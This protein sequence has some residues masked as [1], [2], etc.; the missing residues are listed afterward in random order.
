MRFYPVLT[1][2]GSISLYNT[3]V[4]DIYHSSIGAYTEALNKYTLPSGIIEYCKTS[5][6]VNIL[7]TCFGLG[8]N[9]RVS[10]TEIIK[11]NP[12]CKINL[13]I[14]ENDPYVLAYSL[15]V[16]IENEPGLVVKALK[17]VILASELIKQAIENILKDV[18]FTHKQRLDLKLIKQLE[19]IKSYNVKD[20]IDSKVMLH[21]I[22]YPPQS[23][24]NKM[25][26]KIQYK[27]NSINIDLWLCDARHAIQQVEPYYDFIFH[28]PFTPSKVPVLWTVD[29]FSEYKRILSDRGNITTYSSNSAV[30]NG[31]FETG[32]CVG[33]T[34]PVGR[35]TSG[36]IAY[37][38][39]YYL[40]NELND[41]EKG[42]LDTRSAIP[43]IDKDFS[44]TNKEVINN[45]QI[46]VNKSDKI[47]ASKYLRLNGI[48]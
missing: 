36:T 48:C 41:L 44:L 40:I 14:L 43:Y 9:S 32:L 16:S 17:F 30:R 8:Y 18:T 22:Y 5:N 2:D 12:Q 24:S 47:S 37:K 35:K 3:E 38:N 27:S 19:K 13:C 26:E 21:N 4:G 20:E 23:K 7:D 45:R 11:I 42:L 31:M 25:G 1:D 33:R 10:I 46:L 34:K 39:S 15:L 6:K 28:D 29:F